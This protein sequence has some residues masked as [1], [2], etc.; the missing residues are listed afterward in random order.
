MVTVDI[1]GL[2]R[3]S[4]LVWLQVDISFNMSSGVKSAELIKQFKVSIQRSICFLFIYN[5][6]VDDQ[7][8]AYRT[9]GRKVFIDDRPSITVNYRVVLSVGAVPLPVPPGDGAE[10]VPFAA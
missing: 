5:Q 10:A 2:T 8:W 3:V 7:W 4:L 6:P 1:N 9:V